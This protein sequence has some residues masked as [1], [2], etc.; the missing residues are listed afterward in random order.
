M[1]IT[2][3]NQPFMRNALKPGKYVFSGEPSW[4][5]GRMTME[6]PEYEAVTGKELLSGARIVPVYPL[7][8]GISQKMMR[9]W[10]K[11]ALDGLPPI[12]ETLPAGL[13]REY[14]L[15]NRDAAIRNIHYPESPAAFNSAR[16]TL[17]FTELFNLQ[18]ALFRARGVVKKR[19]GIRL[20]DIDISPFTERLGFTFTGAQSKVLAEIQAD[21]CSG[22]MM[23]RL[24]QGDVGSGKTAVAMAAM[25]M[26]V[27]S[28]RQ[29]AL[30]APTE[31]LARQHYTYMKELF[32]PLGISVA[33]LTGSLAAKTKNAVKKDLAS[34]I[35][36]IAVGTH[37]L[38]VDNVSF[39]ALGL[40]ICDEQ[41][42]FGVRQR[43][44]LNEKGPAPHV[45]VMTAT[46]IPRTL[47]LIL[48]GDLDISVIDELPPGRTPI[49][50]NAVTSQYRQRI[51]NFIKN[52]T[53]E[54][55]QA[56]IVCPVIEENER[57][58]QSVKTYA[59]GFAAATGLSPAILHGRLKQDE[60]NAVME[61]FS[62]GDIPVLVAT[63]VIEVGIN[64]PNASIMLIE[65]AER[66][67]LA[68]LH[69]LRGRV[70]RGAAQSY[71]VLVTDAWNEITKKRMKA[72]TSTTDGFALSDLDLS[73]RGPG[74]FFGTRQHGLPEMRVANLY[75]DGDILKEAQ[76]AARKYYR[77][78]ETGDENQELRWLL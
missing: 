44:A 58:L 33:L 18:A 76:A 16:R 8:E 69:Q 46:P 17:A 75:K 45:L 53:D 66:F 71:C 22:Y 41:H 27:K 23:N 37:A 54:G 48:Y 19:E 36:D 24:I 4:F 39:A 38:I 61:G 59:A 65:N 25:Y 51:F 9:M 28:G 12:E 52:Q 40:T 67:G 78:I 29:A 60:K 7:T 14:N 34:G 55:R 2:W 49:K 5:H 35:V 20:D 72:M 64:V 3:Y 70:G 62:S 11:E 15:M 50:T 43:G 77:E 74:D 63:T 10:Q 42:R 47:A 56:Y 31:T 13:L 68:Q 1:D 57:D 21:T 6:Q 26:T 30:M 32:E 73:I